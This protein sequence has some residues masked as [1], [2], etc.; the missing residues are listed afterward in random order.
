MPFHNSKL[1]IIYLDKFMVMIR[2]IQLFSFI[3]LALAFSQKA[4]AQYTDVINTNRPGQSQGAFSVGTRVY[5]FE[6][7]VGFGNEKHK[8]LNTS[9]KGLF[10][11]YAFRM[12][13]FVEELELSVTG[14]FLQHKVTE[15]NRNLEY[16]LRDF[17]SNTLGVKYL[18][19]D[20]HVKRVQKGPNLYS[21]NKNNRFQKRDLIPAISLYAGVNYDG[22]DNPYIYENEATISPKVAL[23]TQNNWLGGWVFV[24]NFIADRLGTDYPSYE[25]MLTLT[26]TTYSGTSLFVEN[27]GIFGDFYS[28]QILRFGLAYLLNEHLQIDGSM[29]V[30]FKD[31]PEKT[32]GRIGL[33]Y[34]IDRHIDRDFFEEKSGFLGRG[35]KKKKE[36]KEKDKNAKKQRAI[37]EMFD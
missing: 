11:E 1:K 4:E 35:N 9:T 10:A 12:G 15:R 21:W 2:K 18:L 31:T 27:H 6:T 8:L 32:Y 33:S 28:D 22:K 3:L 20:P 23:I 7:G 13:L 24:T 19:Y 34:R 25:Y 16:T 37:Q 29:Q 26:H 17:A 30:N 36:R 5:Q 14:S